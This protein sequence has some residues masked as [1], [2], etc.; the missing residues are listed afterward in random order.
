M[1]LMPKRV[2]FRKNHR[3]RCRGL[4]QRGNVVSFG[5]YGLKVLE[6]GVIRGSQ[7]EASRVA[8]SR[9]LGTA[10]KYWIRIF[11]YKSYTQKPAETRMGKGKGEVAFWGSPVKP[12]Q[13]LFEIA[14]VEE[15]V[16]REAFRLQASK[17]P[18]RVKMV[19]RGALA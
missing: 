5:D 6:R 11:P 12:G 13:V 2:K 15:S 19:K 17:L 8:L 16:A 4:A 9:H 3:G 18:V 10:G 1:A 14:G 7:I